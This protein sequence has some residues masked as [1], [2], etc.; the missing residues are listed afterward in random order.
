MSKKVNDQMLLED[1]RKLASEDGNLLELIDF[2]KEIS[3]AADPSSEPRILMPYVSAP[4][5]S[6]CAWK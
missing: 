1:L 5:L 6:E 3:E 4:I 2:Y